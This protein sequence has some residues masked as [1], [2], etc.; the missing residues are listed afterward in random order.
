MTDRIPTLAIKWDSLGPK[1][2]LGDGIPCERCGKPA[3]DERGPGAFVVATWRPVC[4]ACAA[5]EDPD[6]NTTLWKI[7]AELDRG[8]SGPATQAWLDRLEGY[9]AEFTR[10]A[11]LD[12]LAHG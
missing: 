3:H 7:R 10:Q 5:R 6:L 8:E 9:D 2:E 11:L 1:D 4:D 12:R